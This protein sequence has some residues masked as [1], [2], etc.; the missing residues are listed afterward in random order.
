LHRLVDEDGKDVAPGEAG[1]ALM[2]GPIVTKGYHNNEQVNR[3]A[4]TEDG[5]FR[6][7]DILRVQDNNLYV[8]DRKKVTTLPQVP[9]CFFLGTPPSL[10]VFWL[11]S[12]P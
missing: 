9:T 5:W 10:P 3:E 4:F 12:I 6:T 7:G 1:E 2:K 11:L 8:V